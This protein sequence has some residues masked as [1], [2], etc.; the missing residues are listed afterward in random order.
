[1]AYP[2]VSSK[3]TIA[4][5]IGALEVCSKADDGR[6]QEV[7]RLKK[8]TKNFNPANL[9]GRGGF[10]PVYRVWFV[11]QNVSSGKSVSESEGKL[12]DG[13]LVAVKKIIEYAIT[14]ELS[15][16]ADIYSFGVLAWELYERSSVMDL[17]DPKL[18]EHGIVEKDVLQVIHAAFLCL[19]PSC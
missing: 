9:L 3:H 14:G 6:R 5:E 16:K 15:E 10:G 8:A 13:G 4:L 17:V 7:V 18:R 12:H 1:M 2:R 11:N 19:Q